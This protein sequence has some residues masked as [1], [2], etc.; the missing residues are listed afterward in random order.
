MSATYA[1]RDSETAAARLQL[2]AELFEPTTRAFLAEL[3]RRDVEL[4]LD[5]G[6]GPGHTTRLIAEELA[7]RRLVGIDTSQRFLD[8]AAAAGFEGIAHDVTETPFPLGPADL[9]FCR[10]LLSHVAEP[11]RVLGAW[12][13]E[14][15]QRGRIL[16]EEVEWI[17]T[18][19]PVFRRYLATVRM[20]LAARN[21][22]LEVGPV[23]D[24]LAPAGL[25]RRASRIVTLSPEPSRVAW[26]FLLNLRAWSVDP[27]VPAQ[28]VSELEAELAAGPH[29]AITWGLRQIAFE[30]ER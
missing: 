15:E 14:L 23:L 13:S 29:G 1:F 19:D 17:R 4:A 24:R 26:M 7:P 25:R 3:G 5:L 8:L 21:H 2:V 28:T 20:L 18:T 6:C 16:V 27:L 22:R 9:L 12:P 11:A 10:F 30:A